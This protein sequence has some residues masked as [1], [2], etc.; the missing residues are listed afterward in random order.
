MK[1]YAVV[2]VVFGLASVGYAKPFGAVATSNS[3]PDSTAAP[4]AENDLRQQLLNELISDK[5]TGGSNHGA[6]SETSGDRNPSLKS[7]HAAA[8][9][10][11]A[12]NGDQLGSAV[13]S[14]PTWPIMAL[15]LVL[16]G[17]LLWLKRGAHGQNN[18]IAINKLAS[19]PL[20]GKR[21]LALVDVLGEKLVLGL[22]EK[23]LVLLARIDGSKVTPT[24]D[25]VSCE[26]DSLEDDF[27]S[28]IQSRNE[29][30]FFNP[31]TTNIA[32]PGEQQE[33]ARKFKNIRSG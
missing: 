18:P 9:P 13:A 28:L 4:Q 24:S 3:A 17:V 30:E 33:L 23:G 29:E 31:S 1:V 22:S 12:A 27:A 14:V 5:P 26:T 19:V 11:A 32:G 21:S 6:N 25:S 8:A 10:S 16:G 7:P 15:L 2:L 20:G